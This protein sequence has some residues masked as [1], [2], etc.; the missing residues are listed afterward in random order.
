MP[1]FLQTVNCKHVMED[2]FNESLSG[3]TVVERATGRRGVV[4]GDNSTVHGKVHFY[5]VKMDGQSY[6]DPDRQLTFD[7]LEVLW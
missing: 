1:Q 2:H 4:T 6:G 3:R 5:Y 7:Q